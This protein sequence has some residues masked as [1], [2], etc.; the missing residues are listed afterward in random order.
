MRM[1]HETLACWPYASL[2][3][4]VVTTIL[5]SSIHSLNA[6]NIDNST[7]LL[8]D[9]FGE[10]YL[11]KSDC[12]NVTAGGEIAGDESFCPNPIF[13]PSLIT[14]VTLP[15]GGSGNL[16]YLW[17]FTEDDP[18]APLAQ[19]QPIPGS[20]S[21][22]YDPGPITLTTHYMRCARREGCIEY[23]G[24]SNWVT[25]EV[26]CCDN[27]L[28]GGEICCDQV[29]CTVPF[30]PE[31]ILNSVLPS[32]GTGDAEYAWFASIIGPPFAQNSPDWFEI[33]NTN[34]E[35]F[36]SGPILQTTWF[37][38]VARRAGCDDYV[39]ES[40][41]VMVEVL[42]GPALEASIISEILCFEDSTG[43][44]DLTINGSY[45]PFQID[46]DNGIGNEE[47]PDSLVAGN[48]SVIVTDSLGCT[49]NLSVEITEPDSLY[50]TVSTTTVNCSTGDDGTATVEIFGGTPD[51]QILW[52]DPNIQD[53]VVAIGLL[54][55][56]YEVIVTD[57]NGCTASA[58]AT[59]ENMPPL[60]LM[61]AAN[62]EIC[63]GTN[64]GSAAVTEIVNGLAPF[65]YQW[66]DPLL[67][68]DS[69]ATNLA[70]GTYVVSVTDMNNCMGVDSI[71]IE[72]AT[73][74]SI[75]LSGT[76]P[77]CGIGNDGMATVDSVQG[78]NPNYSYQWNDVNNQNTQTASNLVA[79]IYTVTVT[80]SNNCIG[81]DSIELNP[82]DNISIFLSSTDVTCANGNDGTASIDSIQGGT[83][84]YSYLWSD[85]LS[86]NTATASN[87]IPGT[88]YVTVT[89]LGGCS[90]VDSVLIEMGSEI[91][92]F[93]SSTEAQCLGISDGLISIDSMTNATAPFSFE[94][95]N[96]V[97]TDTTLLENVGPGDYSVTLTDANGCTGTG[98]ITVG[99]A[100]PMDAF[101]TGIN[102]SCAG[103][104][105]G[106]IT[107]DS[108]SNNSP[109]ASYIW[110]DGS[111]DASVSNLSPGTY[112]VVIIAA[113][114]CIVED[115]MAIEDGA[116]ITTEISGT[117]LICN[118]DASGSATVNPSGGM[119]DY[120]YLW[121]DGQTTQTAENLEGG[122]YF[123]T[124]SYA[125]GCTALDSILIN[126]PP[127][128]VVGLVASHISCFGENDGMISASVQN[129]DISNYSILWNNNSDLPILLDLA[130]GNYSVTVTNAA[131]CSESQSIDI[132][133]PDSLYAVF[134][135]LVATCANTNDGS[136]VTSGFGGTM[137]HSYDWDNGASIAFVDDLLPGFYTLTL[138]DNN[139]CVFIDSVEVLGPPAIDLTFNTTLE[140]CPGNLDASA[141]VVASGGSGNV[142]NFTYQ[143]NDN[144]GQITPTANNLAAGMYEVVVTDSIGCSQIGAVQVG[145][146]SNLQIDIHTTDLSC[147]GSGDG[148]AWVEIIDGS[149]DYAILWGN[150]S[151]NDSLTNL[152]AG[153]YDVTVLDASGC[154]ISGTATIFEPGAVTMLINQTDVYCVDDQNGSATVTPFGGIAPHTFQWNDPLGQTSETL[155]NVGVGNYIV[156]VTDSDG[157]TGTGSVDIIAT[158]DLVIGVTMQAISCFG[159]SNGSATAAALGGTAPYFFEWSNGTTQ[160]NNNN[161]TAGNYTVTVTDSDGCTA[162]EAIGIGQ[163][164]ALDCGASV[165]TPITSYGGNDGG[166]TAIGSGGT[167]PYNYLWNIG[168]NSQTVFGLQSATYL[169]T[170]TDDNGCT[171]TSNVALENP[172]KIG[173]FVWIDTNENGSQDLG[174]PGLQGVTVTL[175]GNTSG[176]TAVNETTTSS[177]TGAYDFDGLE[178]GFYQLSFSLPS[179]YIYTIA[180]VGSNI[181]DSDVDPATGMTDMFPIA[182]ASLN[183]DW[184]A[185]FIALDDKINL[186][187]KVWLD[188]NRDGIQ[189]DT[190]LGIQNVEVRLFGF[191][192]N[193]LI[194]VATTNVL[195]IYQFV[196]ILPG[197]YYI[198]FNEATLPN[199][200][201]FSPQNVGNDDEIDS[202]A[203]TLSGQTAVF[204]IFPFTVDNNSF[205]AGA[206][207]ECSNVSDGGEIEA[208]EELCGIGADPT[209]MTNVTFPAGGFGPL[210]YLWLQSNV[211][212][213]NGPSDP[214]WTPIANSNSES[215]DPGP[216]TSTTYYLRCARRT[217]CSD[218]IGESNIVAKVVTEIPLTVIDI[219][220]FE[221][222]VGEEGYF[223][224]ANAGGGA[225]YHW[226]FGDDASPQTSDLR[227]VPAVSWNTLGAKTIT[228]TVTR[229]GCSFSSEE[230][231]I[232]NN[233]TAPLIYF[234]NFTATPAGNEVQV[235]WE[236]S[237]DDA[238]AF[239]L[240][241]RSND[242]IE[243][244]NIGLQN[245][246]NQ[247]NTT[248][249]EFV[250]SDPLRGESFYRIQYQETEGQKINSPSRRVFLKSEDD[251]GIL[252][253]PNP[254][255]TELFIDITEDF[256]DATISLELVNGFAQLIEVY[257]LEAGLKKFIIDMRHIPNG[258]YFIHIKVDGK[259]PFTKRVI[260]ADER[261]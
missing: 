69:V 143:W 55:G 118:G 67:Q 147:N 185:G 248:V 249:Y 221:L 223:E 47:D 254:I 232:I 229:F 73:A 196:D 234:D 159:G 198:E 53:S 87:L 155:S 36:D 81:V 154:T 85:P 17:I 142:N 157:C 192:S 236:N 114:G 233:C 134:I 150:G 72:T 61:I 197:N 45:P 188:F 183:S 1:L 119:L 256:E 186:G 252:A 68:T 90:I 127:S 33:P 246:V 41:M 6:K 83:P 29:G 21:P 164:S 128:F 28:T 112:T 218:Y 65:T 209:I 152:Q 214:N 166:I 121:S 18:T 108:L 4:L 32:G 97:T 257:E 258:I 168:A 5:F 163:P 217:G 210:E 62:P 259:K 129:D 253:Y 204:E 14:N 120:T 30:D 140:T 158:S 194:D 106:M 80:D 153:F 212:V 177:F 165:A 100:N 173:D 23:G 182:N 179:T 206:F 38:R 169:V 135:P 2:R 52:N 11:L 77:N 107:V 27:L 146:L 230:T 117:D 167:P 10:I 187:D 175:T 241:Q 51:Y 88:Y 172:A 86:Q 102:V 84:D 110:F 16:E 162:S 213:Y 149:P 201:R 238:N 130:A 78:G 160:A 219:Y 91:E 22:E 93:L 82:N 224:A 207:E 74:F 113:N 242:N 58:I 40:N 205:D 94:W 216:I 222:C 226:E 125:N 104:N 71:T 9:D 46:W 144:A 132:T 251:L 250:D 3:M 50:V 139:N 7:I 151:T 64:D 174:E 191:P 79:G 19:W 195:G 231:V 116:I 111:I 176:G 240:I 200:F 138:T 261:F 136:I 137:P 123:V 75:F 59:V 57:G 156:T 199:G 208:D 203:D 43:A 133:E 239:Y 148:L 124:V 34:S 35:S 96:G 170:V 92:L 193:N 20:N 60:S 24:E 220:P 8:H 63:V 180:N 44:I 245:G 26:V 235:T 101:L 70:P 237:I 202:D 211:P 99:N 184:D 189:D 122:N 115:S 255:S 228:L 42:D 95:S 145:S 56:D 49:S 15:S 131:G 161:L 103:G 178:A 126:E 244:E 190:E 215:Y 227:V 243:F 25:K 181:L 260:K 225:T 31:E 54:P 13:D 171:C 76:N 105:D 48:Y 37:V 12:D 109:I 98:S 141:T 89:D 39:G 247:S 66:N